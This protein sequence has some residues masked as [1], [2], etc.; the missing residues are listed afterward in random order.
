MEIEGGLTS[1]PDSISE[2]FA[3]DPLEWDDKAMDR[4]I[5]YYRKLRVELKTEEA[6]GKKPK[7]AAIPKED[8]AGISGEDLLGKLGLDL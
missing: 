5:A 1:A 4:M 2:L 3:R 6:K 7:A 8:L